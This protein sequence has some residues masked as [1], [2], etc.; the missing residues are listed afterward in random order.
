MALSEEDV[1]HIARLARLDLDPE[2]VTSMTRELAE[3]VSYI[4]QLQAVDT[5]GVE[6]IAN[7]AGLSNVT[8][9][10]VPGAMLDRDRVLANAP[11]A[12]AEAFLVPKAV[13]R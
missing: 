2:R 1:R 5:T 11:K 9:P 4:E 12:N 6:P 10:D 8:R 3:I 7:V 13:E